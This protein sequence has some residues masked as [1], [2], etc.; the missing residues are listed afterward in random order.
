MTQPQTPPPEFYTT[1]E[2]AR[3]LRCSL[4]TVQNMI[5]RQ[6]LPATI[7][8]KNRYRIPRGA[9]EALLHPGAADEEA[10]PC[11]GTSVDP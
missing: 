2:V 9:L 7:I 5:H 6:Q 1:A 8:G 4:R 11:A 10:T 3:L